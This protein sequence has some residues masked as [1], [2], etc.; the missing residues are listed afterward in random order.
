[1][2]TNRVKN[3]KGH[4]QI[5]SQIGRPRILSPQCTHHRARARGQA[6][7]LLRLSAPMK[8]STQSTPAQFL[9]QPSPT[10]PDRQPNDY[11]PGPELAAPLP[12]N[13]VSISPPS[14]PTSSPL[15][16]SKESKRPQLGLARQPCTA[17]S[18]VDHN[19]FS[20][21]E[22]TRARALYAYVERS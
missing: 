22:H 13:G 5:S 14:N 20:F 11:E 8:Q 9:T 7:S 1:M 16:S 4:G 12:A 17:Y 21:S 10:S 19:L 2:T 15:R 18:L 3:A 6:S